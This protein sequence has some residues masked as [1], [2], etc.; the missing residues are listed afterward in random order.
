MRGL[1]RSTRSPFP[2]VDFGFGR[3]DQLFTLGT[4]LEV[5]IGYDPTFRVGVRRP[6]RI[7]AD[8]HPALVDTG[9]ALS[10][11]DSDLAIALNLPGAGHQNLAGIGGIYR[12]DMYLAQICIPRLEW[13]V[14]GQFAGVQLSAGGQ[15]HRALL[16]RHFLRRFRLVYEGRTGAVT[17]SNDQPGA[18]TL[19][20]RP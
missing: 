18:P 1:Q 9:S 20:R 17:L 2:T 14:A 7:P 3:W 13:V 10:C 11:I 6:P 8:F 19:H 15:P 16:G 4:T 5:Q 12:A